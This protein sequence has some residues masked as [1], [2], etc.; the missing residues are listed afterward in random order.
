MNEMSFISCLFLLQ[1]LFLQQISAQL[2]QGKERNKHCVQCNQQLI[3]IKKGYTFS[4]TWRQLV[5]PLTVFFIG[6][7][8]T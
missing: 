7:H 1:L 5:S 8:I 4:T 6:I 2:N 3:L